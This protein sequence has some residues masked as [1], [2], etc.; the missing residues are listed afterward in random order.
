ID[1]SLELLT[2][3]PGPNLFVRLREGE[4]LALRRSALEI[5]LAPH[6]SVD[7]HD[8]GDAGRGGE[9]RIEGR[10]GRVDQES[11]LPHPLPPLVRRVRSDRVQELQK[12]PESLP[13]GPGPLAA[14]LESFGDAFLELHQRRDRRVEMKTRSVLR[15][16]LDGA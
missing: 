7:L 12:G 3:D 14:R 5:E 2:G 6:L 13:Q 10:P 1:R 8:E 4:R 16:P 11:L 9:L 15:H